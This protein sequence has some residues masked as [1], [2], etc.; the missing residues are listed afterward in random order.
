MNACFGR[1]RRLARWMCVLLSG[2]LLGAAPGPADAA[3]KPPWRLL[4]QPSGRAKLLH[5]GREVAEIEPGLFETGWRGGSFSPAGEAGEG[6]LLKGHINAPSG[7]VVDTELR[8]RPVRGGA[9]LAYRLT[10]RS[11]LELNSLYVAMDFPIDLAAGQP[12]SVE[13]ETFSVPADFQQ[14][15]LFSGEARSLALHLRGGRTLQLAVDPPRRVLVQ[16]NRRWGPTM[17]VRI[18]PAWTGGTRWPADRALDIAFILTAP[19]GV[20]VEFDHPVTMEANE[21]WIPLDLEMDIRPGSALDFSEMGQL[22]PPA[23]RHGRIIARPDGA[24]AFR[25]RPDE[26]RRFYGVNL[27]FSAHYLQHGE[28]DRLAERLMRLGYNTV[29]FHHYE[30]ELVDRSGGSSTELK[31]REL[32][33]LD[34]LFAALKKRGLY[35][36]T[37]LF[38]SRPVFAREVWPGAEGTMEMNDYKMAVLVNERARGEL[39]TFAR[40]LLTHR[41]P[42][43]GMTYGEDPA[44]A[45]ISLINEG[46]AASFIGRIDGR[47]AEDWRSAWNRYLAE[48]Y[49]S[50]ENLRQAWHD[51]PGGDPRADNVPLYRNPAE[52]SPRGRDMAMFLAGT[53]L[54]FFQHMKRFLRV[55]LGCGALLTNMNGWSCPLSMQAARTQ[56]DYVDEH[57]YVDHPRFIER[58]WRLPA[59]C[60]NTNPV[61]TGAVGGLSDSFSNPL[62]RPFT[63]SEY[64][65]SF[66]GKYRAAG[67]LLTGAVAALQGWDTVWRFTYSHSREAVTG[68]V[69]AAYFNLSSDAVNQA[70]DRAA[71]CLYL[72]GDMRPAPHTVAVAATREELLES[73]QTN[74]DIVPPWSQLA[75]VTGL[76]T[77]VADRPGRVP[78]A[79]ILPFGSAE[80]WRGGEGLPLPPYEDETGPKLLEVMR[81]R[82]WLAGNRTDL[83][84]G[85]FESETGELLIDGEAGLM[86]V[87]TPR[88]AG[89]Y[90]APGRIIQAGPVRARVRGTH[91]AVWVSSLDGEPIPR[92]E[93]LLLTHLTDLQNTG[94]RFGEKARDTLL[95]WG[96][97]PHLV[98]AGSATVTLELH[99]ARNVQVWALSTGG[100][101]VARVEVEFEGDTLTVPVATAGPEGARMLYEVEVAR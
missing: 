51:D 67:G 54:R 71:L 16:D 80:G 100:R 83:E 44:L 61:A 95:D 1:G 87:R 93:R 89:G 42:Y 74:P 49:G 22:D 41:N 14:T 5:T 84:A 86:A 90:A 64:N 76:G 62:D 25:E 58:R 33:Q 9:R 46:N 32:D 55:E 65:Y 78:A 11:A 23:G 79:L 28:A 29:R 94:S 15:G 36:T 98:R 4:V 13:D 38:I 37:D 24:F 85:R 52:D 59:R 18:G 19:E 7:A 43:T 96:D 72:R 69:R 27:C 30:R 35:V 31:E 21:D 77:F 92:S 6:G 17:S 20:E 66:P 70:S 60:G 48:R 82:G 63:V 81:G 45:W 68:P 57:F 26:P 75:L 56:F 40:E 39:Q 12:F 10:P 8:V 53:E 101:R 47:L 3:G 34:Y 88:T 73:L 2:G 97:L 99:G 91:A 50:R